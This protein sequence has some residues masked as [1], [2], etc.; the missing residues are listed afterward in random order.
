ME[1]VEGDANRKNAEA[2]SMMAE[3]ETLQHG[4]QQM[5]AKVAQAEEEKERRV[6]AA[7]RRAEGE[8]VAPAGGRPRIHAASLPPPT[9]PAPCS[10]G[11]QG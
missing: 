3:V 10:G 9:F 11:E 6:T 1:K 8:G 2:R 7:E 5:E 4:W